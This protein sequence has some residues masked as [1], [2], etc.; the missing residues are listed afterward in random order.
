MPQ[1]WAPTGP[2]APPHCGVCGVSSY[3][4]AERGREKLRFAVLKT[5]LGYLRNGEV[6]NT[7]LQSTM[8]YIA[9]C[10]ADA[11]F[12]HF[13]E[14]HVFSAGDESQALMTDCD[15]M[16]CGILILYSISV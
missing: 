16:Y 12:L 8:K 7:R 6:R 2:R 9:Y 14:L 10:I 13:V 4:T 15:I 11:L 1:F 5:A 3:A